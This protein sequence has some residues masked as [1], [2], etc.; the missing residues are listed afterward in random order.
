MEQ[1]NKPKACGCAGCVKERKEFLLLARFT[2]ILFIGMGMAALT[3]GL[4]TKTEVE[5]LLGFFVLCIG[6]GAYGMGDAGISAWYLKKQ[7]KREEK[8]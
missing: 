7:M 1:K 2:T 6:A 5:T 8:G 4:A 3:A